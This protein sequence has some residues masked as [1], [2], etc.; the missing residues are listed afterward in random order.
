MAETALVTGGAGF[1]GSHLVQRLLDDGW[2]VHATSRSDRGSS[3]DR[4]VFHRA[5]LAD[6]D[7]AKR[8][9]RAT[10][11]DVVFHLAGSV[12]A[13]PDQSLV[14]ETYQ[15]HVTSTLNLLTLA[16]DFDLRRIVL[17]GSLLEP[18]GTMDQAIPSSPYAAAKVTTTLYARMF[19]RLYRTPVVVVR[20]FMTFGPGQHPQKL[21]P[22]VINSLVDGVSPKLSSGGWRSDW[23]YVSDVIDGMLAAV[24]TTGAE[25]ADIDLGRGELKSSREIVSAVH[26]LMHSTVPLQFGG[27][28]DRPSAPERIANISIPRELLG[29]A[30][31]VSLEDGLRQ[32]IEWYQALRRTEPSHG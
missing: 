15:S 21:L 13:A 20:P 19:Y 30:P 32:T 2:E 1:L 4:L 28:E 8:I 9:L 16:D 22:Y 11:P 24:E 26:G 31:R 6:Y 25:G 18:T 3:S 14:L 7:A 27:I 12:G 5:D 10:R 17:T 29:W 23:I